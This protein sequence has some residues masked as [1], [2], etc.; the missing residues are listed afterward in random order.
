MPANIVYSTALLKYEVVMQPVS[1]LSEQLILTITRHKAGFCKYLILYIPIGA[2]TGNIFT[3]SP[4]LK[5]SLP[6]W[7]LVGSIPEQEGLALPPA[8][9]RSYQRFIIYNQDGGAGLDS[10]TANNLV[11]TITGNVNTLDWNADFLVVESSKVKVADSFTPITT[12]CTANKVHS[13]LLYIDSFIA[14]SG[15]ASQ[16]PTNNVTPNMKLLSGQP[17]M[18]SW[19]SNGRA[20]QLYQ[21]G[22]AITIDHDQATEFFQEAGDAVFYLVKDGIATNTTFVLQATTPDETL[23]AALTVAVSNPTYSPEQLPFLAMASSPDTAHSLRVS[24]GTANGNLVLQALTGAN[25]GFTSLNFNGYYD[26]NENRFN[27]Q[28]NRWRIV[29]DQRGTADLF[30]IET[31]DGTSGKAALTI[32]TSGYVGIGTPTPTQALDV[33]GNLA[34]AGSISANGDL[35]ATGSSPIRDQGAHLQWNRTGGEGETW[36]LNQ[37]GYGGTTAGIRFGRSEQDNSIVEWARFTDNGH[38]G[39]GTLLPYYPLHVGLG[40]KYMNNAYGYLN[41]DGYGA[42]RGEN[43]GN[44][45][46]IYADSRI[47]ASEFN[48]FSDSRLKKIVGLSDAA[49]DLALLR[50]LR[51]TDYTMHD[52]VQF[53]DQAFKKLIGQ[54]LEVVFSQAVHQHPDFLPDIYA[55]AFRVEAQGENLL[56]LTLLSG[57]AQAATTG[58]RLKLLGPAGEVIATLVEAAEIGSQQ[59]LVAGA[60]S[61]AASPTEVFV[62]GLEH[63]D[64]RTVDYEAVAMLNVS[65]TQALSDQVDALQRENQAQCTQLTELQTALQHLQ[66]QVTLLLAAG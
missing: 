2:K 46:S 43:A 63:A 47:L 26:S 19:A 36:L 66:A 21:D 50:Q 33:N 62:F 8:D 29:A 35:A 22:K 37:K 51:I 56:H 59:L 64:V 49:T 6:A 13:L 24:D 4:T 11:I 41:R 57:L 52:R 53:G 12:T 55:R 44:L 23:Y 48:A 40:K 18:L 58:Q 34:V 14:S 17:F 39:I 65:A 30:K 7:A 5:S 61:L 60:S 42:F 20:Y 31:F 10:L 45:V 1:R 28:K 54:E 38:F 16:G 15:P 27:T 3:N 25:S 9:G 32:A